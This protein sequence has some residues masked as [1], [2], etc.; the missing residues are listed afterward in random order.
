MDAIR[1]GLAID[2]VG[3]VWGMFL[4]G[5]VICSVAIVIIVHIS[6]AMACVSGRYQLTYFPKTDCRGS[7]SFGFWQYFLV[8]YL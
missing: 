1:M 6:F 5:I 3:I 4:C 8:E 2:P 7:Q